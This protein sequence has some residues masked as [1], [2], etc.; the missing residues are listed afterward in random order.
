MLFH[1]SHRRVACRRLLSL[2]TVVLSALLSSAPL[3]AVSE[4]KTCAGEP[5]VTPLAYGDVYSIDCA[6]TPIGDLDQFEFAAAA[7]DTIRLIATDT[8]STSVTTVCVELVGPDPDLPIKVCSS[9]SAVIDENLTVAGA[10]SALVTE[11]GNNGSLTYALSID[12][13][14]PVRNDWPAITFGAVEPDE[15]SPQADVDSR[16]LTA[17][18]GD[19]LRFI[20]TDTSSS[21]IPAICLEVIAPSGAISIV[22]TCSNANVQV[23]LPVLETGDY[24]VLVF[25]SGHNNPTPYSLNVECLSGNCPQKGP[26]ICDTAPTYSDGTLTLDFL[27]RTPSSMG[28]SVYLTF[29][30]QTARIWQ[31]PLPEIDTATPASVPIPSF[32]P[33][34]EIGILSTF[35]TAANGLEC[36]DWET[37]DTGAPASGAS[38]A[39]QVQGLLRQLGAQGQTP[40]SP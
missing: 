37:I 36:S 3:L 9:P 8:D 16:R 15:I 28:W 7:G 14:Y 35:Q 31:L 32:P 30:G 23:D 6:I 12:R 17:T 29:F 18:A 19:L 11:S 33:I 25:E 22:Q 34:G 39:Q 21:S 27:L 10:Y 1:L 38:A 4:A 40:T 20:A 26:P 5:A 2:A 24:T 13:T